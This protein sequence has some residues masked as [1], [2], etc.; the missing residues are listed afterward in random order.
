MSGDFQTQFEHAV[1]PMNKWADILDKGEYSDEGDPRKHK[2]LN[3]N[4]QDDVQWSA[5]HAYMLELRKEGPNVKLERRNSTMRWHRVHQAGSSCQHAPVNLQPYAAYPPATTVILLP[6]PAT[7]SRSKYTSVAPP[8]VRNDTVFNI[9][10]CF[11]RRLN[12][13]DYD[14]PSTSKFWA[15]L[16]AKT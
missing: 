2:I 3:A 4:D 11:R 14:Q 8:A 5:F 1:T 16:E 9:P 10:S 13:G 12:N 6:C 7:P 15:Y